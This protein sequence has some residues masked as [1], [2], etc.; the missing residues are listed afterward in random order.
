MSELFLC[1]SVSSWVF[2]N[3]TKREH[4]TLTHGVTSH[5][6]P[7]PSGERFFCFCNL[8]N[9]AHFWE[10][11][12][13]SKLGSWLLLFSFSQFILPPWMRSSGFVRFF[14]FY[15]H[16][17]A[18]REHWLSR[19]VNSDCRLI[20]NT[21]YCLNV[22]TFSWLAA[23]G[24]HDAIIGVHVAPTFLNWLIFLVLTLVK[25]SFW[26]LPGRDDAS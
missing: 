13:S 3:L 7:L 8:L 6:S 16:I 14:G 18:H 11:P 25:L 15:L 24:V 21:D 12:K 5:L 23:I 9:F 1:G 26:P 4:P 20:V 19:N 22:N 10:W 17:I 2:F